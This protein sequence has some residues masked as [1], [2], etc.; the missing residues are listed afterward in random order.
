MTNPIA[1]AVYCPTCGSPAG[2]ACKALKLEKN[3]IV[4]THSSRRKLYNKLLANVAATNKMF[5]K[6]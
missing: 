6:G 2:W 1:K 4:P 5:F 3:R